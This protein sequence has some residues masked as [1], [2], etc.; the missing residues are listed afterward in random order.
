MHKDFDSLT[1]TD[2]FIFCHVMQDK[3]ICSLVLRMLLPAAL[4]WRY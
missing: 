2:D 1:I 3:T 4:P